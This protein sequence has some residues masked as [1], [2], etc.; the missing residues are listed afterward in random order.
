MA[1]E[2][3][4]HDDARSSHTGIPA[5]P[6]PSATGTLRGCDNHLCAC[7][8]CGAQAPPETLISNAAIRDAILAKTRTHMLWLANGLAAVMI[9]AE[10]YSQFDALPERFVSP[11]WAIAIVLGTYLGYLGM[12]IMD[13]P[14]LLKAVLKKRG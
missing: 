2:E 9:F 10:T 12:G 13:L 14:D 1:D 3:K 6:A 8:N 7:P 5:L 11:P 4:K